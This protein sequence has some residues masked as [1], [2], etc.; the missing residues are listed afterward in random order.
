MISSLR[1][2]IRSALSL[3]D[4]FAGELDLNVAVLRRWGST[5]RARISSRDPH[6]VRTVRWEF[7]TL[8]LALELGAHV[9]SWALSRGQVRLG[10]A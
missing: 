8:E 2:S 9:E 5:V 7:A 10:S 4:P 6:G 1:P 3:R